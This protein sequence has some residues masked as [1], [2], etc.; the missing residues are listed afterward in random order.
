MATLISVYVYAADPTADWRTRW[1][2]NIT[3]D[4]NNRYCDREM[5][6]EVGWLISPF[7]NGFYYGY[8]TTNDTKW[9]DMLDADM[10]K[11]AG[12]A[13]VIDFG[14]VK[15]DTKG[16]PVRKEFTVLTDANAYNLF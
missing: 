10:L 5:G 13:T 12:V 3:S 7:L 14:T 16:H 1:E 11:G 15:N 6:E 8:L 4:A 9:V 2:K